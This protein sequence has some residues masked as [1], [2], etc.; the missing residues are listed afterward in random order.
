LYKY[1]VGEFKDLKQAHELQFK[2]IDAGWKGSFVA[3][4]NNGKRI[5]IKSAIELLQ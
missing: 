1:T 5:G 4:F 2:M 3:A